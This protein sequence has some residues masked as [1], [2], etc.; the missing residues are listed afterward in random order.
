MYYH[1][2]GA[3]TILSPQNL[4][5]CA[6]PVVLN[7]TVQA[8]GLF[9]QFGN[10]GV[11]LDD[12]V[13]NSVTD[14]TNKSVEEAW[15]GQYYYSTTVTASVK[16]PTLTEGT[17]NATVYY[18][19]QY[20]GTQNPSSKRYEV[21]AYASVIFTVSNDVAD[22]THNEEPTPSPTTQIKEPTPSTT[23]NPSAPNSEATPEATPHPSSSPSPPIPEFAGWIFLPFILFGTIVLVMF[24][25]KSGFLTAS[26]GSV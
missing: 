25:K 10:V 2:S 13:I 3:V 12:G 5:E 18:G 26:K 4:T 17:H 23:I 22:T 1:K 11:G 15:M 14:F 24:K 7:F 19:W 20:L 8:I 16:L 6:N 21:S 9:G